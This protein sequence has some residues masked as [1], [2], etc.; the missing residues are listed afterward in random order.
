M[1]EIAEVENGKVRG[2]PAYDPEVMVFKGIPFAAPPVGDLRWRAPQPA[3]NWDGILDAYRFGP[4]PMQAIP[5]GNHE[6]LYAREWN[7]P[8]ETPMS[9]DCLYLNV[10]TPAQ[11]PGEKLPVFVWFFGGGLQVG[12]T[13]EKEFDG[14]RLAKRGIVVVTASYR[15]NVFGFLAHPELTAEAPDAPT[16]FGHLDQQFAIKWVKRNIAAFGGDP[17]N[18]TIGG[19]SAGGMSVC[20]LLTS[21]QSDGLFQRA[22]I[23]SGF[24][25]SP[26]GRVAMQYP[27][28]EAEETG[29]EFFRQ[30][31]VKTLAE[32]RSLSAEYVRD[33]AISCGVFWGTVDDGV[34]Q[35]G[36]Y[37]DRIMRKRH[38]VPL[39]FGRTD[40]EFTFGAPVKSVEEFKKAVARYGDKAERICEICHADE[41]I[42]A[43]QKY[44]VI[45]ELDVA[46]RSLCAAE[47]RAGI[48]IPKYY[49][50]FGSRMPGWDN[51]GAFHS[52]DLWFFF[53]TLAKC[54]R[55][56]T[57]PQ[58]DLARVM[59]NYWANFIKTGDPNGVDAD[60]TPMAEWPPFTEKKPY[61]MHFY[62]EKE[63]FGA[64]LDEPDELTRIFVDKIADDAVKHESV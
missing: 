32:A 44:S 50:L 37:E 6:H 26:Y 46:M 21:P 64:K 17:D 53:E 47:D 29:K 60:G 18:I 8:P 10:W 45:S 24:F 57:G 22:I 39:L 48:T 42:E 38:P 19:Q 30:L 34:F 5:D 27:L 59:C 51:P 16:N 14:D 2:L 62:D 13:V 58:Y 49:Y 55:P 61:V 4:I 33:K 52:S 41:G 15:L 54:W 43:I 1:I 9:E 23:E 28:A 31:G 56:F 36:K 11:K 40:N 3:K 25:K 63:K 7:L 35:Q 20:A 12:S